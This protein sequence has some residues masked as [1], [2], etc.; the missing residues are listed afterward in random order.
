[1]FPAGACMQLFD[2]ATSNR[3]LYQNSVPEAGGFYSSSGDDVINF[4][5][6]HP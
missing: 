3:G 1:M 2:F 4:T 6:T 5:Q